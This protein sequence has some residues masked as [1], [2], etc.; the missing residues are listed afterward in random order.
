VDGFDGKLMIEATPTLNDEGECRLMIDGQENNFW[1]FR[2]NDLPD[3]EMPTDGASQ[4]DCNRPEAVFPDGLG[5]TSRRKA[6]AAGVTVRGGCD[7]FRPAFRA[8]LR[9]TTILPAGSR[10]ANV[11]E[12]SF[13]P[14]QAFHLELSTPVG[15]FTVAL[16]DRF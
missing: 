9:H 4:A 2:M 8:L 11:A 16:A 3:E 1:Q 13:R 6:E 10:R 5:L 14:D 15:L 12:D 7:C